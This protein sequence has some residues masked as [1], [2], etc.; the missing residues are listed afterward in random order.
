MKDPNGFLERRGGKEEEAG[1]G[2]KAGSPRG[3]NENSRGGPERAAGRGGAK[4]H[5]PAAS[6]EGFVPAVEPPPR[7]LRLVLSQPG[8]RS[9]S[10]QVCAKGRESWDRGGH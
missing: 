6:G 9:L 8:R 7:C 5:H 1:L 4:G 3:L 2:Q 10:L